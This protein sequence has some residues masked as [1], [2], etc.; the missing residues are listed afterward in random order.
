[1]EV[2]ANAGPW[3]RYDAAQTAAKEGAPIAKEG[4]ASFSSSAGEENVL[5]VWARY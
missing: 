5:D 1:M 4:A 3:Q 2:Q